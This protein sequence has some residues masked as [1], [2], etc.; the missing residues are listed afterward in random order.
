MKKRFENCFGVVYLTTNLLNGKIYIGQTIFNNTDYL[1]SGLHLI[2]AIKFY[3]KVNFK[4]KILCI[5]FSKNEL[6]SAEKECIKLFN[7]ID[8]EIGYNLNSGG[9]GNTGCKS[10]RLGKTM[11]EILGKE[12]TDLMI[13]KRKETI[14]NN[15]SLQF[16]KTEEYRKKMSESIKKI[17]KEKPIS[18]ET[19]MKL[20]IFQKNR[21][22]SH[23]ELFN[24]RQ[25]KIENKE[26]YIGEKNGMYGKTVYN[27]WEEKYGEQEAQERLKQ[28][29]QKISD[30]LK[31]NYASSKGEKQRIIHSKKMT[32]KN[33]SRY[34]NVNT[35]EILSLNKKGVSIKE[36]AILL[37]ISEY[38]VK[39]RIQ[40]PE[41]FL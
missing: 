15:N 2:R 17:R 32:G 12:K 41:K 36:I 14:K 31:Q 8:N 4:K 20:S 40:E 27:V 33:N 21:V 37:N 35:I 22:R 39:K 19:R 11:I 10:L 3:G 30:T 9:V 23:Q 29:K 26:K 16:F 5:C 34:V 18:E 1:G 13:A 25:Q 38:I 6:D 28:L 7:S 24:L